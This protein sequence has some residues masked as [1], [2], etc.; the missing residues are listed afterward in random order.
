VLAQ[1]EGVGQAG[2]G[3]L[4]LA[5][6]PCAAAIPPHRAPDRVGGLGVIRRWEESAMPQ[7]TTNLIEVL[8]LI[9]GVVIAGFAI[10]G[11]VQAWRSWSDDRRIDKHLG[12]R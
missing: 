1:V 7:D 9:F 8:L 3:A 11:A 4:N 5:Y 2:R 10:G 6:Q 12:R